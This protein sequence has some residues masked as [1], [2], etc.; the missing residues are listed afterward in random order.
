MKSILSSIIL[1]TALATM[2]FAASAANYNHQHVSNVSA[3]ATTNSSHCDAEA[4]KHRR[5][6]LFPNVKTTAKLDTIT[7]R[8][9]T[10]YA[11]D[12]DFGGRDMTKGGAQ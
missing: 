10:G 4:N 5:T 12:Y 7:C 9:D 11:H 6:S 1:S 3:K 2:G 8:S